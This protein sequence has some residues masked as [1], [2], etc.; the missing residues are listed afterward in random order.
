[1]SLKKIYHYTGPAILAFVIGVAPTAHAENPRE[2]LRKDFDS[3]VAGKTVAWV[4]ITLGDMWTAAIRRNFDKYSVKFIVRDPNTDAYVGVDYI[5]VGHIIG[6]DVIAEFDSGN[7][8]GKVAIVQ[9]EATAAGKQDQVKVYAFSEGVE[10]GLFHKILFFR[11]DA[12]G[13]QVVNAV[14]S[15]LQSDKEAGERNLVFLSNNYWPVAGRRN[16]VIL[17]YQSRLNTIRVGSR[18]GHQTA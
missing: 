11:A 15:L 8:S 5:Y 4:P 3:G 18:H 9:G 7:G 2:Q 17:P 10:Q 14:I 12:Q 6:Q 13:E 16:A 1:M